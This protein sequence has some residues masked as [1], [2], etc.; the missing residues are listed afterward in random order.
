M[1]AAFQYRAGILMHRKVL[2]WITGV[3]IG[4]IMLPAIALYWLTTTTAGL[5]WIQQ[6]LAARL[7]SQLSFAA[8]SGRLYKNWSIHQLNIQLDDDTRVDIDQVE[9]DW[10]WQALLS[11]Q[12]RINHVKLK[13]TRIDIQTAAQK[14]AAQSASPEAVNLPFTIYL[15]AVSLDSLNIN[16]PSARWQAHDLSLHGVHLDK[17]LTIETFIVHTPPQQRL[18]AIQL[19]ADL[20]LES[21][22]P[23]DSII[24]FHLTAQ[25]QHTGIHPRLEAYQGMLEGKLQSNIRQ[26]S[27]SVQG[28]ASNTR[29]LDMNWTIRGLTDYQQLQLQQCDVKLLDG[30]LR[31]NGDINWSGE[32]PAALL[33]FNINGIK[34]DILFPELPLPLSASGQVFLE[35]QKLHLK[36]AQ[37]N[38]GGA[39]HLQLDAQLSHIYQ[40]PHLTAKAEWES[41]QWPLNADK[42]LIKTEQ[43]E[44]QFDGN[45]DNYTLQLLTRVKSPDLPVQDITL[46]LHGNT[47]A[48]SPVQITSQLLDGEV[49]IQAAIN[50][51]H[52]PQWEAKINAHDLD[53]S[54]LIPQSN[55]PLQLDLHTSGTAQAIRLHPSRIAMGDNQLQSEGEIMFSDASAKPHFDLNYRAQLHQLN[56]LLPDLDGQLHANGVILGTPADIDLQT[57]L[58]GTNITFQDLSAGTLEA[59]VDFLGS[60]NNRI[61]SRLILSDVTQQQLPRLKQIAISINGRT[62]Q[63]HL[64][65]QA[66][67]PDQ[68]LDLEL[69]GGLQWPQRDWQG[70]ISDLQLSDK[71]LGDWQSS[72]P[73]GL[74][75]NP[76]ALRLDTLCL[77]Q[78]ANQ[79]QICT[80][81]T[82]MHQQ[83]LQL[84][85]SI[86]QLSPLPYLKAFLP[87]LPQAEG[88]LLHGE[89]DST[90]QLNQTAQSVYPISGK[91]RLQLDQG[92]I[93]VLSQGQHFLIPHDTSQLTMDISSNG[94]SARFDSRL[95]PDNKLQA[96]L[97]LAQ[98]RQWPLNPQFP[99]E[100]HVS[101]RTA[102]LSWLNALTDKIEKLDGNADFQIRVTGQYPQPDIQATMTLAAAT[103]VPHL[104]LKL[105]HIQAQIKSDLIRKQLDV[106]ARL[107]SGEGNLE[108]SGLVN[109]ADF[110]HWQ[111]D[112]QLQG[113]YFRAIYNDDFKVWLSPKITL[114]LKDQHAHIEGKVEIPN[115]LLTPKIE[116]KQQAAK[117]HISRDVVIM[118]DN[119]DATLPSNI[120][121]NTNWLL[122]GQL[123]IISDPSVYLSIAD[124]QSNLGGKVRLFFKA[125]HQ[126]PDA[127]GEITLLNGNYKAYG[128]NLEV[129]QGKIFYQGQSVLNPALGIRAVREIKNTNLDGV[130]TAGVDIRGTA[131]SPQI[132]L[133]SDPMVEDADIISYLVTGSAISG[134]N[135]KSRELSIGRY[136]TPRFYVSVGY[137]LFEGNKS[138]NLRYDL[139][140]RWSIEGLAGDKDSG[141]DFSFNPG[142]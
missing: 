56:Q 122:S 28:N 2:K 93:H 61:N 88:F 17:K 47:H 127:S 136:L 13:Q 104:G 63:H 27:F 48:L 106:N 3:L 83:Q 100:A 112:L 59:H 35:D 43:A 86:K 46:H 132:R 91:A 108:L 87:E 142:R 52:T 128:Q 120:P 41:L 103:E 5:S 70:K 33:A 12:I 131:K 76:L 64:H 42:P 75:V 65:L 139:N 57:K 102:D 55:T 124:F 98:F 29:E 99:V 79:D 135:L 110:K 30:Q 141:L 69:S 62:E 7:P 81:I 44:L 25:D 73:S 134:E 31:V 105:E 118:D 34:A 125:G 96:S 133:F 6:H 16:L 80:R 130:K 22:P 66:H 117:Q 54:S 8:M 114:H 32:L 113:D 137:D 138:F 71:Q 20:T 18:P 14:T 97:D 50:W 74:A 36:Q 109:L 4:L 89:V 126:L 85:A 90:L 68:N 84:S 115:A 95:N 19:K 78:Q 140:R 38:P 82:F 121:K 111:A 10:D 11:G 60:Q 116:F 94:L 39:N 119:P 45:K 23:F 72:Q 37:L 1:A 92:S 15:G 26:T 123:D 24:N 53:L 49:D 67:N 107:K 51:Q 9:L 58:Q 101:S 40:Q 77:I 21:A 129:R